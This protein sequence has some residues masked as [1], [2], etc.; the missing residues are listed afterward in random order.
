M[1]VNKT[2]ALELH[3]RAKGKI[4]IYPSI[5][6]HNEEDLR[7][8][9]IPGSVPPALAIKE[10]PGLSYEY[11]GKGNRIAVIT[12]GSAVLGLGNVG[13]HAALPVM[14]GKCLLFKLFGDVNAM[15]I[16]L[17]TRCNEDIL[18]F[19]SLLAPTIG[20]INIEDISSPNTFSVTRELRNRVDIPVLC[21]DQHGT[22]VV[23]LAALW[24]AMEVQ[25]R[26]L[27]D[28]KIV[29]CG[30]GAAGIATAELLMKAGAGNIVIL[31]SSGV[32]CESNPHMNHIQAEIAQRTNPENIRGGLDETIRGADV[33][34]GLSTGGILT[35]DH[36]HA[37]GKLPIVFTLAIP[38]PEIAPEL[39]VGAGAAIV[40]TGLPEYH[41]TMPNFHSS[42]GI[43]RGLLD[44]RATLLNHS[45][46]LAGARALANVVDRRRLSPTKITP[47]LFCDEVNPR[48][49]EAVGQAAIREGYAG[50]SVPEGEIYNNLWQ[51]LYGNRMVRI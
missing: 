34:I 11:T 50:L 35:Q 30:A 19:A 12:D 24:N 1:P 7:M 31:N 45:M 6:I 36:V 43:M 29:V 5:N 17:D 21:D 3:R 32:L 10:D 41:N 37:M 2:K 18:H 48:V 25:D 9:Y 39:A 15:P 13:P 16:C 47:D 20:G 26:K 4:K 33:F 46:L 38:E 27:E 14:E 40:A 28:V 51:T 22:A 8:A 49:A 42:P 44:V 23:I